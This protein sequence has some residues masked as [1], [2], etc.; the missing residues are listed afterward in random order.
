MCSTAFGTPDTTDSK[1]TGAIRKKYAPFIVS[2]DGQTGRMP[3]GACQLVERKAIYDGIVKIL[4]KL[5][6]ITDRN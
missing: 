5:V 6:V 4:R 3:A 2:V 1:K